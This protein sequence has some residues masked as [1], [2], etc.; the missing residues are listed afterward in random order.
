EQ[1]VEEDDDDDLSDE[2]ELD[3]SNPW[4]AKY[5]ELR[6]YRIVN[7]HC[8]V[9][10]KVAGLGSWVDNQ[11]TAFKKGKLSPE[12]IILLESIGFSFGKDQPAPMTFEEGLEE[13]KKFK[14]AMGH[15]NI[16]V[17]PQNPSPLAKWCG[18]QR[19]EYK[20]FRKQ[21]DSLLDLQK[22]GQLKDAGF[23]WKSPARK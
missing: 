17:N 13:L 1:R 16:F 18:V 5:I 8:N 2:E 23:K 14:T 6:Q 10:R 22:I 4:D 9:P 15:C 12:R 21:T 19:N 3:A 20:R 11:K 7:G